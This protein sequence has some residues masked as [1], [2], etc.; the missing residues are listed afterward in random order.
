MPHINC[1]LCNDP[2]EQRTSEKAKPYF[3]CDRCGVQIFVRKKDGI[4]KLL[5]LVSNSFEAQEESPSSQHRDRN[6]IVEQIHQTEKELDQ[7]PTTVMAVLTGQDVN[8]IEAR[9]KALDSRL[10]QLRAELKNDKRK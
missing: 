9:H 4:E 6:R 1:F 10:R 2:L 7:L 3:V 5:R 8:K